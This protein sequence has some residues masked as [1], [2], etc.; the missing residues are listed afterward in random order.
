MHSQG[1][2][3]RQTKQKLNMNERSQEVRNVLHSY[4]THYVPLASF[5]EEE[6]EGL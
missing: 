4:S 3:G 5:I 1:S 6:E 2:R